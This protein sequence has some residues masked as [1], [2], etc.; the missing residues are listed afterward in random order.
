[1]HTAVF[2][3]LLTQ[4]SFGRMCVVKLT[5]LTVLAGTVRIWH[6]NTYRL[7]STLN[8]GLERVWTIACQRGSN[9]VAVG[10]DEGSIII[11]VSCW[12]HLFFG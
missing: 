4:N 8:Y 9:N 5:S 7:E 2:N 10:Y 3:C 12:A 11:K 1:M 6:A